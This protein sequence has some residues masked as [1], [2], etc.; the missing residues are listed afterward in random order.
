MPS[1]IAPATTSADALL[2]RHGL[3]LQPTSPNHTN[4]MQTTGSSQ[5]TKK[6]NKSHVKHKYKNATKLPPTKE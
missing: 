3:A 5:P 4:S 6:H 2:K 1:Q